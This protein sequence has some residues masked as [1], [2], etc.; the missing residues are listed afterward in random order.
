MAGNARIVTADVVLLWDGV[1]QRIAKGTA[2]D[3]PPGS[4][5]EAAIGTE[6]L[7][8]VYRPG[9]TALPPEPPREAPAPAPRKK[10]ADAGKDSSDSKGAAS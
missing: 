5:L 9:S 4:A 10:A 8:P 3:V 1:E 2:V 7:V 6:R